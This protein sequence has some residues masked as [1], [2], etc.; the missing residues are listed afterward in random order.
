MLRAMAVVSLPGCAPGRW[1]S[2]L[3]DLEVFAAP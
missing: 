2:N 1:I 3:V